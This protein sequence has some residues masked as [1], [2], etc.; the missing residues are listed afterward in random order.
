MYHHPNGRRQQITLVATA[1]GKE[2]NQGQN[3]RQTNREEREDEC[4]E[5]QVRIARKE[6]DTRQDPVT[7]KKRQK[8]LDPMQAVKMQESRKKIEAH[9][10][11]S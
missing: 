9:T 4:N 11:A 10:W 6:K 3:E 7:W 8:K 1:S 5:V 2:Y